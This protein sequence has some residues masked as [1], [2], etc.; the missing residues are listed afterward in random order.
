M[1]HKEPL[2]ESVV[3]QEEAKKKLAFYLNSYH[4]T[5]VM[6]NLMFAAQKG[7]GKS[8][9]ARETAKELVAYGEDGKPLLKEDGK[10]LKKKK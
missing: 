3:G 6:P 4:H 1:K 7:Q 5:R 8:L 9:L 2:F 10:T